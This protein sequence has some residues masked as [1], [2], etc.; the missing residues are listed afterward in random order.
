VLYYS[1]APACPATGPSLKT[2]SRLS[3][4]SKRATPGSGSSWRG[5]YIRDHAELA[6]LAARSPG[7]A[8]KPS[9]RPTRD[10]GCCCLQDS[11]GFPAHSSP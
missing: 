11:R 7:A 5:D 4:R 10:A 8:P 3:A 1:A 2:C 9:A 6:Q